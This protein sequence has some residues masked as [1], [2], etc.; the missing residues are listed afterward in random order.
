[1]CA[2][3]MIIAMNQTVIIISCIIQVIKYG[4]VNI[5]T[6]R[7]DL[8]DW[9]SL[10][11]AGRLHKPVHMFLTSSQI[12]EAQRGNLENAFRAALLL[13]PK[14]FTMSQL[15]KVIC[16]LSYIGDIR[17][18]FAE[19]SAKVERIVKGMVCCYASS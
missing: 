15:L 18:G 6:F 3:T 19:D 17:L 5:R 2:N 16:S 4:V 14:Y 12:M 11:L 8:L 1:M 10:Y 7:K 9:N 13:C